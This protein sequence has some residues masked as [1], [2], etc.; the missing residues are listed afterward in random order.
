MFFSSLLKLLTSK[1]F[2]NLGGEEIG[3]L[4]EDL[5]P[6]EA[7][8]MFCS[9]PGGGK[10]TLAGNLVRSVVHGEPFL[11]RKTVKV[12]VLVIGL[13]ESVTILSDT[14]RKIGLRPGD[15][16]MLRHVGMPHN[17]PA[18]IRSWTRHYK[19][20]LIIPDTFGKL[21]A[22][23]DL[24][25]Y[26]E[27]GTATE[28]ALRSVVRE[29]HTH[30]LALH[31]TNRAGGTF[32]GSQRIGADPDAVLVINGTGND[33]RKIRTTKKRCGVDLE[34]DLVFDGKAEGFPYRLRLDR[35]GIPRAE[36]QTDFN[37]K[38]LQEIFKDR[39]S[40]IT[41]HRL[42]GRLGAQKGKVG[43]VVGRLVRSKFVERERGRGVIAA[44]LFRMTDWERILG[45]YNEKPPSISA[46]P[47]RP[48]GAPK[49]TQFVISAPPWGSGRP[50]GS[51][52]A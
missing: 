32:L 15:D 17:V 31:H 22:G 40:W 34:G 20:G 26:D 52:T 39:W 44:E 36:A 5:L 1:E 35:S 24:N 23:Y 33:P 2:F 49:K 9:D 37:V 41:V 38:V 4:V 14:F 16:F 18:A 27:I 7:Y 48:R 12:P 13:D 6:L 46:P 28:L 29:M 25:K 21:M 51:V 10:T 42:A 19:F 43:K 45:A 8:S 3:Y 47:R 11:E 30:I 50:P